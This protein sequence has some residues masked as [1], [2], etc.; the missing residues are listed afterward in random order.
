MIMNDINDYLPNINN[1]YKHII[2]NKEFDTNLYYNN[3]RQN[4]NLVNNIF[5]KKKNSGSINIDQRQFFKHIDSQYLKNDSAYKSYL[6]KGY[7]L[8]TLHNYQILAS[9]LQ[10]T[11]YSRDLKFGKKIDKVDEFCDMFQLLNQ[12]IN[13]FEKLNSHNIIPQYSKNGEEYKDHIHGFKETD[14]YKFHNDPEPNKELLTNMFLLGEMKFL[15]L[16]GHDNNLSTVNCSKVLEN[17]IDL[18]SL[19]TWVASSEKEEN[20]IKNVL[21][22]DINTYWQSDGFLPHS[23]EVKFDKLTK[24]NNIL[25]FFSNKMDQSYS[26]SFI[27]IYGGTHELDMVLLKSLKIKNIEG[28]INLF[29]YSDSLD[30]KIHVT[31]DLKNYN[32]LK[33]GYIYNP[34]IDIKILKINIFSNQQKGKDSHLRFVRLIKDNNTNNELFEKNNTYNGL[35]DFVNLKKKISL[36]NEENKLSINKRKLSDDSLMLNDRIKNNTKK[37][38]GNSFKYLNKNNND[39]S[40]LNDFNFI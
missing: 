26:P 6:I 39:I 17:I 25:M 15:L 1:Y 5:S 33:T 35:T 36:Q 30:N 19:G 3:E 32:S 40:L 9:F 18:T 31:D 12:V 29:F 27:K 20:S 14:E 28:W 11:T 13:C 10:K 16:L 23:I 34:P 24:L 8:Y 21:N 38:S 2:S 4:I 37:E 7:R 22:N